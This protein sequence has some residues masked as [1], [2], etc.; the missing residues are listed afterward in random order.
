MVKARYYDPRY[1]RANFLRYVDEVDAERRAYVE[2]RNAPQPSVD[3]DLDLHLSPTVPATGLL[4]C[5]VL[6]LIL[7][8]GAGFVILHDVNPQLLTA[9]LPHL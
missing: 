5:I 8:A 2:R 7:V 9:I 4:L 3:R 1:V 6:V